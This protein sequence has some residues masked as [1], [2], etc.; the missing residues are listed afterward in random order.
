M[1]FW[2]QTHHETPV[3]GP[4]APGTRAEAAAVRPERR[5]GPQNMMVQRN[6]DFAL[7]ETGAALC[8][9]LSGMCAR[10]TPA[11]GYGWLTL[12]ASGAA[13]AGSSN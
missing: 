4:L 13:Q 11:P 9:L 5:C 6:D 7:T 2:G 1:R 8:P 12:A 10:F 3:R